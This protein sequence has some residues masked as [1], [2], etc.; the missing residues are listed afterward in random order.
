MARGVGDRVTFAGRITD[1]ELLDHLA[2]CRVV[3]FPP[4]EEDYGFVTAEAFASKKAVI[5]CRDSG[6]PAELVLDGVNG[7]VAEPTPQSLA[8]AL[9]RA[10]GDPAAA[11]RMGEAAFDTGRKLNWR[12][13]VEKL[14]S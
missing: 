12:D 7:V 11:R 2:R 3:C 13:A 4:F 10:M 14:T 6:G 8:S 1:A 5:T 9:R